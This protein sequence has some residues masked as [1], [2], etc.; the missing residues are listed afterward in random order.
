MIEVLNLIFSIA[1]L[2]AAADRPRFADEIPKGVG[3]VAV[4]EILPDDEGFEKTCRLNS[5]HERS[6]Q[7]RAVDISPPDAYVMDACRKLH[8]AKWQ[9]ERD[10]AGNIQAQYYFCRYVEST[11]DTAFCDRQL[12]E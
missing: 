11:P 5:V 2:L 8:T 6:E 7:A 3:Y 4:L 10:A 1:P 12:G 9:V